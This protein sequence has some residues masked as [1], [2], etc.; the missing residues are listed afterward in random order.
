MS[1]SPAWQP[2]GRFSKAIGGPPACGSHQRGPVSPR[3]R[4]TLLSLW[5]W[6][7]GWEQPVAVW[8]CIDLWSPLP[9]VFGGL[10]AHF[11]GHP[12]CFLVNTFGNVYYKFFK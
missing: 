5:Q 7:M 8:L 2:K 12:S 1:S 4:S 3:N 9:S 11:H 6:L 10:W